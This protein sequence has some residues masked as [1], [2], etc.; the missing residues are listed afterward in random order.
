MGGRWPGELFRITSGEE[1]TAAGFNISGIDPKTGQLALW[2]ANHV[3]DLLRETHP[4]LQVDPDMPEDTRL[5]A[6]LQ[7]V[8]GGTWGGCIYEVDEIVA[9][10]SG[11]V[12]AD[13]G[14][15]LAS[16]LT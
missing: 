1:V 2:Q 4:G 12:D 3:A 13:N 6:A 9:R 15:S 5:W 7:Q 10:L 11:G 14:D 8:G 16:K